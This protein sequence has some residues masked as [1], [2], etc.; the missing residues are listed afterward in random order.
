MVCKKQ[1]KSNHTCFAQIWQILSFIWH[2]NTQYVT[3]YCCKNQSI[4]FR[5]LCEFW[6]GIRLTLPHNAAWDTVCSNL[7]TVV[8]LEWLPTKLCKITHFWL[9]KCIFTIK[10]MVT[11]HSVNIFILPP[12]T[13]S[14]NHDAIKWLFKWCIHSMLMIIHKVSIALFFR[15]FDF[16]IS[17]ALDMLW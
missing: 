15:Y 1:N 9:L 2:P 8:K 6:L 12:C 11:R 14:S 7:D 10:A 13:N 16:Q 4:C 3:V 17:Y 5:H